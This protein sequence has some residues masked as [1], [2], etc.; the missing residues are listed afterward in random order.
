M[1]RVALLFASL[2]TPMALRFAAV[3]SVKELLN[4]L[5]SIN[6]SQTGEDHLIRSL[7]DETQ[8]GFYVDVGCHDPIR[9]SN[10][11]SLYLHGWRGVNIDA[12]PDLI[13][14]FKA[15]RLRDVAVCAAVSDEERDIVFHEFEDPL[16]S[17]L[18]TKVLPEWQGKWKKRG[19]RVVKART[20][21]SILDEHVP[22]GTPID[23]LSVDVEGHDLNVLR[24]VDLDVYRPK[25]IVV[26]MHHLDL[27]HT[28]DSEVACYLTQRD[29]RQ[30]GY[31]TLNGYFVD[32]RSQRPGLRY[33][34]GPSTALS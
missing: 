26:E 21:N 27:A 30:I 2:P 24:S 13:E 15:T 8:P 34:A 18:D 22:P 6:Y 23:L 11:L 5:A 7:L 16:V 3:Y 19:E 29:F 31:D 14:R 12:N 20:L 10:T 28:Q 4:S 1:N 25:L 17:T 32:T 9:S 33:T